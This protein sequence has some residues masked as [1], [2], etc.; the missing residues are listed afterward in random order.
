MPGFLL[1]QGSTVICAHGG[2]TQPTAIDP[3]VK[4]DGKPV[5][6]QVAP[7]TISGCAF[8]P[9]PAGNGP[10]VTAQHIVGST[11]VLAGFLPVLLLDSKALATPT[12]TPTTNILGN[13]KVKGM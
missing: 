8:P 13:L 7:W 2:K 11:K 3:K 6:T 1:N 12:G 5:V 9:P 10:C 4:V